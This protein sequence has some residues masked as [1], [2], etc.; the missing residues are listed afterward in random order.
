MFLGVLLF[1]C[2]L[3][4]CVLPLTFPQTSLQVPV[5]RLTP[6]RLPTMASQMKLYLGQ[7]NY[8]SWSFRPW[9]ALRAAGIE[10]EIVSV[11]VAGKGYSADHTAFSPN[12]LVPCLHDVTRGPIVW[13][14]LAIIEYAYDNLGV[15]SIWPADAAARAHARCI[16]AEMHS[17][18]SNVRSDMSM[19]I[20]YRGKGVPLS[21][22]TAEE[23]ARIAT[24]WSDCLAK[25]GGP[26]LFGATPCGADAMYAPVVCRFLS[27]NVPLPDS[28]AA[29]MKTMLQDAC[30][31]EYF[32]G[33]LAEGDELAI[34]HYDANAL[35]LG[36]GI[37]E[38][39]S[40]LYDSYL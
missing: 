32:V 7:K 9:F 10:F 38:P 25:Y 15:A 22:K 20:K 3:A 40:G 36:G 23:V 24:L 33:A 28:A 31:R 6:L 39:G 37:R 21:P 19:S 11:K 34:P 18:F 17:G 4:C 26:Y 14:S 13:D 2:A 5:V 30:M 1:V 35:V 16:S 12:G 27:Y 29:Y 8:S